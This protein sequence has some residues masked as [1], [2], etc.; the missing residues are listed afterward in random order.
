LG[1]IPFFSFF[2]FL[3]GGALCG[4]DGADLRMGSCGSA[5]FV[6]FFLLVFY[7]LP[8]PFLPPL[9]LWAC[10]CAVVA[11]FFSSIFSLSL[12]F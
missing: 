9:L 8:F 1:G 11:D 10:E 5:G 2:S 4:A 12:R 3:R 7:L 6:I